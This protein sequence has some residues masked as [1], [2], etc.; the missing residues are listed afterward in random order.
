MA[1][2]ID[3]VGIADPSEK[4]RN[5]AK[6][7]DL[8]WFSSLGEML[9]EIKLDGIVIATPNQIHVENGLE[10]VAA[11]IPMLLEKPIASSSMESK[12]LVDA[13][14][15]E[16]VP[17]LIG[18]Q[19]RHN[20]I[21]QKARSL[22]VEGQ[23]GKITSVHGNG[24]LMK[25][26]NYFDLEWRRKEGAGPLMINLIHEIDLF[27]YLFGEVRNVH[28]FA[29]NAIRNFEVEDTATV[30]MRFESDALCT[31]NISDTIP[32]PWSWEATAGE[33]PDHSKTR[34]TC[35]YI[36]GTKG[37]LS[38]P[39]LT[40]WKHI[41]D[42]H[43]KE[44]ICSTS[45]SAVHADPY[46]KQMEHFIKVVRGEELPI[47]SGEEGMKSLRVVEAIKLSAKTGETIKI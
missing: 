29:S 22:I 8:R 46:L 14:K 27:R 11:K 42:G 45:Y 40:L 47:V 43:W 38:I 18:H 10:C 37:S 30:I 7:N 15:K 6:Q 17:I 9:A 1:R 41:N 25:P 12:A 26:E 39:G 20:P 13:A 16:N 4:V 19:R 33:N 3:F 35:F 24:W 2:E 21:I 31:I 23:L 5:Y 32:S 44:P 36:G 28:A 34:Q